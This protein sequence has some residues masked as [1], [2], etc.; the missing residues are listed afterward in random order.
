MLNLGVRNFAL[1]KYRSYATVNS[2]LD[3]KLVVKLVRRPDRNRFGGRLAPERIL[4]FHQ[5]EE[6]VLR[7]SW[8]LV[9]QAV[10]PPTAELQRV[11]QELKKHGLTGKW[12]RNYS[13]KKA[14]ESHKLYNLSSL[15]FGP[16]IMVYPT[17]LL[18]PCDCATP[19]DLTVPPSLNSVRPI[20]V[21]RQILSQSDRLIPLGLKIDGYL[22]PANFL[23][24]LSKVPDRSDLHSELL[25]LLNFQQSSLV[26]GLSQ[27][28]GSLASVLDA[29][30]QQNHEKA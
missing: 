29:Y 9:V 3:R 6:I 17:Q 13:F 22:L 4:R 8:L 18:P 1:L 5:Y 25:G 28:S 10:N 27:P 21:A 11:Q 23:D 2:V 7:S 12:V 30:L 24:T 26:T 15:L 16:C 14:C 20:Q 19:S